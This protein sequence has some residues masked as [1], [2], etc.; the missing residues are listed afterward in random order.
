M[1]HD[2]ASEPN[3]VVAI[4]FTVLIKTSDSRENALVMTDVFSK[5]TV[6]NPTKEQTTSTTAKFW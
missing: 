5:F 1:D 4:D 6:A 2:L 3:Q